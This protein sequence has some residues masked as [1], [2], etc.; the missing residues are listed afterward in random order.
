M[1]I[2]DDMDNCEKQTDLQKISTYRD[3][4]IYFDKTFL[5]ME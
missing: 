2:K 3:H 1:S 5:N 4:K